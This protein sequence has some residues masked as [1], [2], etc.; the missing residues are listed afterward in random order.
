MGKTV[1]KELGLGVFVDLISIYDYKTYCMQLYIFPS[2]VQNLK[3][4]TGALLYAQFYHPTPLLWP[5]FN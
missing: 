4:F 2:V 5:H 1:Q 3:K